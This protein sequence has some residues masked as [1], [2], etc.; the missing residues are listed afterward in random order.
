MI[1]VSIVI[2][3]ITVLV[4]CQ[5]SQ[6]EAVSQHGAEIVHNTAQFKDRIHALSVAI[7]DWTTEDEFFR[8]R[9]FLDIY[10][11]P[12]QYAD[13]ALAFYADP[14]EK[15]DD[16]MLV[17]YAMQRL[18]LDRLVN[19]VSAVADLT[20]AGV[21]RPDLLERLSLAPPNFG[22]QLVMNCDQP[23]VRALLERLVTMQ[24]LPDRT[25]RIIKEEVLTGALRQE[26][27]HLREA[28]QV[29]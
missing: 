7:G 25:R 13:A 27:V 14:K 24:S 9:E 29:R 4:A 23:A 6:N 17:G 3:L 10:E 28:G 2:P 26:Y 1:K 11:T 22:A 20:D 21:V 19:L 16:K 18:P 8:H 12:S 15:A 5:K